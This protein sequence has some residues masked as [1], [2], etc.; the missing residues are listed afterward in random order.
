MVLQPLQSQSTHKK[1]KTLKSCKSSSFP[2]SSLR[3]APPT[4]VVYSI[5]QQGIRS[6]YASRTRESAMV[7]VAFNLSELSPLLHQLFAGLVDFQHFK[8]HIFPV[9]LFKRYSADREQSIEYDL[10]SNDRWSKLD[11]TCIW[12]GIHSGHRR[13]FGLS[14]TSPEIQEE[15]L[16]LH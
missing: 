14:G 9:S 11:I 15:Y 5:L 12:K 8:T 3:V 4:A 10:L 1:I 2:A 6:T 16:K 7:M 13:I